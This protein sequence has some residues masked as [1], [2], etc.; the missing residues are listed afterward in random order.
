MAYA[1]KRAGQRL[2]SMDA[3]FASWRRRYPDATGGDRQV[4]GWDEASCG[5]PGARRRGSRPTSAGPPGSRRPMSGRLA[6]TGAALRAA[7]DGAGRRMTT[8]P[9]AYFW[10][11]DDFAMGGAVDRLAAALAAEGGAPLE[12]WDLRGERNGVD[13][14]LGQLRERIATPVMFGGGTLAVV[15]NAG[16]ADRSATTAATRS[17]APSRP[18]RPGNA[19]VDPRRD[20][21][22]APKGRR[23]RRLAKAVAAAGGYVREFQSPKGDSLA[24]WIEREARERGIDLG[25]GAANELAER[26]GGFVQQND[27]ER[28]SRRGP[29][30]SELDKLALYRGPAPITVDDV[31]ALVAEAVPGT[32]W[33]FVDAVGERQGRPGRWRCSRTCSTTT[34]E[35]VLLVV[36]HRRVRE[37]LEIGDRVGERRDA[38]RP[39]PRRMGIKSEFRVQDLRGQAAGWTIAELTD[40]LD[41][42][43]EL[44]A[45]VKHAPG[46]G[47]GR[48]AAPTGV[49]ALGDGPRGAPRA[50]LGQGRAGRPAPAVSRRRTRP[51]PGR[52]GRSRWRRRSGPRPGRAA[53]S[54]PG[55]CRAASSPRTGRR[56]SRSTAARSGRATGTSCRTGS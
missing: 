24:G 7:A 54:G 19:L 35:P 2:E 22:R 17:S 26:V 13:R 46:A 29:R 37:L 18:W 12:R 56:G 15:S 31:R 51:V 49:H 48:R 6:W 42:L 30:R 14:L 4:A 33:G 38:C 28:R 55:R 32:V 34:P 23:A 21:S 44:D 3:R 25:P 45:M 52:R 50:A 9:L 41:G 11:D 40:A 47:R 10:G 20:A 27:A 53:R 5:R 16:A 8:S 1:D 36:L 43:L 39:S